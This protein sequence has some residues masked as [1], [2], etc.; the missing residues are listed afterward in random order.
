MR[1]PA[2]PAPAFGLSSCSVSSRQYLNG[3]RV[4]PRRMLESG[5]SSNFLK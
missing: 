3:Q 2:F 1:R 4:E 5:F